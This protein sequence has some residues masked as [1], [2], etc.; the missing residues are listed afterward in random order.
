MLPG[1]AMAGGAVTF[2]KVAAKWA[3]REH[4]GPWQCLRAVELVLKEHL[5]SRLKD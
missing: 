2:T 3:N 4:L 1:I 5:D